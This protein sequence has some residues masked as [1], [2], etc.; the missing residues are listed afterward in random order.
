[1]VE[2]RVIEHAERGAA[3]AAFRVRRTPNQMLDA[4]LDD[5]PGAH[6]ARLDCNI[7]SAPAQPVVAKLTGRT[8]QRQH[9][10]MSAGINQMDRTI[11][12][13]RENPSLA[14]QN[15]SHGNFSLTEALLGLAQGGT[16]E[17]FVGFVSFVGDVQKLVRWHVRERRRQETRCRCTVS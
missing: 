2:L 13:A 11:V 9:F 10:G 15:R 6:R 16:H 12:S 7:E 3:G 17:G 5:G 8:A 4:G 1:M 14:N